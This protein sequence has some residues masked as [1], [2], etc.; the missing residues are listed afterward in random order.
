MQTRSHHTWSVLSQTDRGASA[1]VLPRALIARGFPGRRLGG[2]RGA[3]TDGGGPAL[4]RSGNLGRSKR[5][6]VAAGRNRG[7]VRAASHGD[8]AAPER[9]HWRAAARV[10]FFRPFRSTGGRSVANAS[11]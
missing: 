11:A 3:H 6:L 2:R 5:W 1:R 8:P 4:Q 10:Y 9:E 7:A